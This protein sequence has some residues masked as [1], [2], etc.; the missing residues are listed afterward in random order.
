MT[1]YRPCG[2]CNWMTDTIT[3]GFFYCDNPDSRFY[4]KLVRTED[5]TCEL[6]RLWEGRSCDRTDGP[7]PLRVD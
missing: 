2:L 5:G 4:E 6:W 1:D 7:T 3:E